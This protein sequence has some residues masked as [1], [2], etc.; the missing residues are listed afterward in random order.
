M[1]SAERKNLAAKLDR[2]EFA[3]YPNWVAAQ[4]I[5]GNGLY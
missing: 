2:F 5:L 3:W 4:P 1:V